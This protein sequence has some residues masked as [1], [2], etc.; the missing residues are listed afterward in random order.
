MKDNLEGINEHLAAALRNGRLRWPEAWTGQRVRGAVLE[1]ILYHGLAGLLVEKIASFEGWPNDLVSAV[2]EQAIAQAMWELGHRAVLSELLGRLANAGVVAILLKGTAVAYDLYQ[3]PATRARGDS[4]LLIAPADLER[5]RSIIQQLGYSRGALDHGAADSRSSQEEWNIVCDGRIHH[6]IDLHWQLFNAMALKDVLPFLECSDNAMALPRLSE[7]ALAMS[8]VHTLLHT[9]VHR[10]MH[11]TAPYFTDG[12]A[13]Y[14]GDRLIWANDIDLLVSALSDAEWTSFCKLA[15]EKG[16]SAVCLDGLM[17]AQR[18]LGTDVPDSV[19]Q[20]LSAAPG[21]MPASTYLLQSRQSGR[22]WRDLKAVPGLRRK[23]AYAR[24][25]SLPSAAF[26]RS[27][28]PEMSNSPLAIL[29]ARRVLE[30][31]RLSPGRS[32]VR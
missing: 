8:R 28:Y 18:F 6:Q 3:S 1:A 20:H 15:Q 11:F 24:A 32:D 25:L 22:A 26:M 5:T 31:F 9:C 12:V 27:K 30:L 23:F 13:Y 2:H 10:A 21:D 4:D 14:G 16:I 7:T 19:R 17:M 29:Y